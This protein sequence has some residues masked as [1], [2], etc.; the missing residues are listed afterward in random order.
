MLDPM[1]IVSAASGDSGCIRED[2]APAGM[3]EESSREIVLSLLLTDPSIP[4]ETPRGTP[5]VT[6]EGGVGDEYDRV[7]DEEGDD[8]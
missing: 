2:A 4:C 3:E 8:E 1:S 6:V 7:D 5:A